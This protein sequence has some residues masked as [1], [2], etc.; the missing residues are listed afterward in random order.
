[1]EAASTE[2][3]ILR[4]FE[5]LEATYRSC[6]VVTDYNALPNLEGIRNDEVSQRVSTARSRMPEEFV[7]LRF[8]KE[9][10]RKGFFQ[11]F[12]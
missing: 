2:K 11:A 10:E 4:Y 3:A 9:L 7:D 12:E 5:I 8:L 1:M 6:I